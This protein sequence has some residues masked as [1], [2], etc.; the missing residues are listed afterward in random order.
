MSDE[1][2][3]RELFEAKLETIRS[4]GE[5]QGRILREIQQSLRDMSAV[6]DQRRRAIESRVGKL[7]DR[8]ARLETHQ[9][10]IIWGIGVLASAVI[11]AL[12][13]WLVTFWHGPTR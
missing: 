3:L 2:H 1:Q 6:C 8:A 13:G 4:Q 9:R 11:S 10:G 5:S 7:E 12:L